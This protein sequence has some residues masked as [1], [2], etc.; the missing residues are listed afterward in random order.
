VLADCRDLPY[1]EMPS[2]RGTYEESYWG[3]GERTAMQSFEDKIAF[4]R[5]SHIACS[6]G[7]IALAR[8]QATWSAL[9][10]ETRPAARLAGLLH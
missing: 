1:T 5:S 2:C 3:P 7:S 8:A 6:E 4:A 10:K 9:A